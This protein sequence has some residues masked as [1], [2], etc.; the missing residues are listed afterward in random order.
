MG[1]AAPF[2]ELR[3]IIPSYQGAA[4]LDD[5]S[6]LIASDSEFSFSAD[7][8]AIGALLAPGLVH[9]AALFSKWGMGVFLP[10]TLTLAS[11][12]L[13]ILVHK[14][15]AADK[16]RLLLVRLANPSDAAMARRLVASVSAK[17]T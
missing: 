1:M 9:A 8:A 17:H 15:G 5:K 6:R 7:L 13:S 12:E 11:E 10:A 3:N 2:L 14:F 16:S 4:I